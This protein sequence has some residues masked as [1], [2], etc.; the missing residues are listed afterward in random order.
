LYQAVFVLRIS[1]PRDMEIC[2]GPDFL[3][4][5]PAIRGQKNAT[6]IFNFLTLLFQNKIK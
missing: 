6:K 1:V 3:H 5:S 4:T 2:A